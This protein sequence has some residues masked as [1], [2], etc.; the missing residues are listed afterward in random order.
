MLSP[1]KTPFPHGPAIWVMSPRDKN[2]CPGEQT[3]PGK[4]DTS[5]LFPP[6][7]IYIITEYCRYGDLVDYLHR[8]KHTFLQSYGEKARREAEL[9][10]NTIKEDHVQRCL[11]S[12]LLLLPAACTILAHTNEGSW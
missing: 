2:H 8:N 10:G 9:Y 11:E 3:G 6:G 5:A 1:R 12:S 4:D 7:P